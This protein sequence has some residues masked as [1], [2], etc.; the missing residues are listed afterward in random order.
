[1]TSLSE[2]QYRNDEMI[3]NQLRSVL[4]QIPVPG[5]PTCL[6]GPTLPE[7]FQG[8]VDLGAI[9][10]ERA[11]DHGMPSYNQMRQAYGLSPKTSFTAITGESTDTFPSG[12]RR[13]QPQQPRLPAYRR[14]RRRPDR[15]RRGRRL[16]VRRPPRTT[17]AARLRAIY[18]TVDNVDAFVGMVAEPHVAGSEFG[19]L[20]RAIW[21]RQFQA[22]RDGDRFFYGNDMGLS[23]IRSQYGIDFHTTLAQVIA[24]NT[25]TPAA[26][27]NPNVFLV[28]DDDLPAATCRVTYKVDHDLDRQLPGGTGHHQPHQRAG[29]RLD[30]PVAVRQRPD[31]DAGL[32]RHVQPE[33]PERDR[34]ERELERDP[35]A[36][37]D[38]VGGGLQRRLRQRDQRDP[39]QHQSQRQTLRGQLTGCARAAMARAHSIASAC[40]VST[41]RS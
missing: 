36:G 11:R 35:G 28:P 12:T 2:S 18:G 6:D 21:T 34:P 10:I 32:E 33:R 41:S 5:N 37:G 27:I 17:T 20:Q 38:A 30:G 7:C 23:S 39:T 4:F 26:D 40:V 16:D 29:Q 9:D 19:E 1:M 22:L 25:D 31:R 14:H 24:R 15:G 3:D 8:V 13:G